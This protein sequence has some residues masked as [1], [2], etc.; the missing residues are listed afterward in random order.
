MGFDV[1]SF[2]RRKVI[3]LLFLLL[4]VRLSSIVCLCVCVCVS[5]CLCVTT[6]LLNELTTEAQ[7]LELNKRRNGLESEFIK[8]HST[9][10]ANELPSFK[11]NLNFAQHR[12]K[13]Q[14]NQQPPC[15]KLRRFSPKEAEEINA[16][17]KELTKKNY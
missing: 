15:A 1:A 6:G 4:L 11:E 12:I 5:L 13:I 17:V 3:P 2:H 7:A 16:Q 10:F 9:I 8:S 14:S